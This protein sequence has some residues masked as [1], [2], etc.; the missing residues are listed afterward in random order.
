LIGPIIRSLLAGDRNTPEVSSLAVS[1]ENVEAVRAVLTAYQDPGTVRL[2][3]DEETDLS[4]VDPQIE[5]DGSRLT[6][7]IPDLA[8]VFHGHE[9]V[10]AYW[11]RWMDAWSD[12][13]FEVADLLDAGDDVVALIVNQRQWGRSTGIVTEL[14]PYAQVFTI[15]DGRLVRW[16]TYPDQ[17]EALRA[18]GLAG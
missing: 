2:L 8:E 4:W 1:R 11:G 13:E 3:A 5:W 16:R 17:Q 9:G 7:M 12:V 15:R 14:P 6:D 18:V 10:R